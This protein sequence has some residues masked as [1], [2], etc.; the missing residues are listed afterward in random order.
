MGR[1]GYSDP[2]RTVSISRAI[3]PYSV[4]ISPSNSSRKDLRNLLE[5]PI[6]RYPVIPQRD[7]DFHSRISNRP[8]PPAEIPHSEATENTK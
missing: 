7:T 2:A 3:R 4:Q 8:Y 5:M 6:F 1:A